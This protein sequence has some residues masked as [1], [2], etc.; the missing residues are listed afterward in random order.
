ML[1]RIKLRLGQEVDDTILDEY[2][3]G[4]K[5]K[6]NLYLGLTSFPTHEGIETIVIER[7]I[8]MY[9]KRTSEGISNESIEGHSVSYNL[10]FSKE[11]KL[12]LDLYKDTLVDSGSSAGGILLG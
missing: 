12:L 10:G 3:E 5:A 7:V 4:E 9:N 1:D 11:H 6:V 2:I 8:E